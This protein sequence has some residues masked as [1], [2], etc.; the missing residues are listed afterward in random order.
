M[1]GFL[2]RLSMLLLLL[3]TFCGITLT[4]FVALSAFMRYAMNEPFAFT[5]EF[6]GLLFAALVFLALP[7]VTLQCKHIQVTLVTDLFPPRLR[8]FTDVVSH[9]LVLLFCLWFGTY[10]FDFAYFSFELHSS[11]DLAGITLWP[12]MGTMVLAS[13]L[14]GIFSAVLIIRRCSPLAAAVHDADPHMGKN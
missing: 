8:R 5:E 9:L 10:A 12:W 11:T 1:N 4:A 2:A 3:A 13:L 14:M 6:V 7:Y